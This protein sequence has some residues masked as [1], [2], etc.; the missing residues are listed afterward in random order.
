M[1]AHAKNAM[2]RVDRGVVTSRGQIVIPARMRRKLKIRPGTPVSFFE[3]GYAIVVQPLTDAYI[4][5]LPGTLGTG[6]RLLKALMKDKKRER[7]L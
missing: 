3:Q 6:G 7:A 5:S 4:R 2:P 1:R